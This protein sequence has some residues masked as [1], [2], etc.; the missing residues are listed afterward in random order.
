MILGGI[1]VVVWHQ[2]PA[3]VAPI[4]ALY[5]ILPGFVVCLVSAV[6]VSLFDKNKDAEMLVEFDNYKNMAD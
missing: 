2:I 3:S 5:E 4:F 6:I 1:T